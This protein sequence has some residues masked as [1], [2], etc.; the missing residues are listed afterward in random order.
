M[1]STRTLIATI[2]LALALAGCAALA[3]AQQAGG[4]GESSRFSASTVRGSEMRASGANAWREYDRSQWDLSDVEW[5]R[6]ET[7]MRGPRGAWSPNLDPLT[8]LALEARNE[9]ELRQYAEKLVLQEQQRT[10]KELALTRAYGAA[11]SKLFGDAKLFDAALLQGESSSAPENRPF[12]MGDRVAFFLDVKCTACTTIIS[13]VSRHIEGRMYPGLDL[14]LV[15]A[16]EKEIQSWASTAQ[17]RRDLIDRGVVTINLDDGILARLQKTDKP[18]F[19]VAYR[20]RGDEFA[21]I[22]MGALAKAE[23][24]QQ[25]T[26]AAFRNVRGGVLG[27]ES[28]R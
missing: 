27:M 1:L 2:G 16:A 28:A 6:Y 25:E 22:E 21:P 9:D 26:G 14:Y 10:A 13:Q 19:P 15:G 18:S 5:S 23:L 8:A 4:A 20:R 3:F 7:I 24:Y 11:W 12:A 17:L